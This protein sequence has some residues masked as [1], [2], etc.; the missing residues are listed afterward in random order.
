MRRHYEGG[1]RLTLLEKSYTIGLAV[2]HVT[3]TASP[4]QD[5]PTTALLETLP[6]Q[7]RARQLPQV[8]LPDQMYGLFE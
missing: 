2:L 6:V 7:K 5:F 4:I 8:L 1:R 3:R